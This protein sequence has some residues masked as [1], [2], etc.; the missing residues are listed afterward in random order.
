MPLGAARTAQYSSFWNTGIKKISFS[1]TSAMT[2]FIERPTGYSY[3]TRDVNGGTFRNGF[4]SP[5]ATIDISGVTGYTGY[6]YLRSTRFQ[7]FYCDGTTWAGFPAGSQASTIRFALVNTDL[8][9]M[10]SDLYVGQSGGQFSV[11]ASF[12]SGS[13][14]SNGINLPTASNYYNTWLTAVCSTAETSTVYTSWTGGTAGGGETVAMRLALYDTVTGVLI[15]KTDSWEPTGETARINWATK[16]GSTL[17]VAQTGSANTATLEA[18]G[19]GFN[20]DTGNPLTRYGC[21]WQ[22]YGTMFDPLQETTNTSWLTNAPSRQ[23]GQGQPLF[24]SQ[25]TEYA[26][27]ST[28][29]YNKSPSGVSLYSQADRR[30]WDSTPSGNATTADMYSSTIKIRNS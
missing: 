15:S 10:F 14:Q 19:T 30:D 7:T 1:S 28:V 26:P 16:F 20:T 5:S 18:F 9:T 23:I 25:F 29:N 21:I 6:N 27:V 12:V 22:S 2:K 3:A 24:Q 13:T 8:D 17:T 4:L 11:G